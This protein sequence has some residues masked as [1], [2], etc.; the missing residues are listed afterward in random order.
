ME[1][2]PHELITLIG[3]FLRPKD[4]ARLYLCCKYWRK[5]CFDDPQIEHCKKYINVV[6]QL[7]MIEYHIYQQLKDAKNIH[8]STRRVYNN[9]LGERYSFT[10]KVNKFIAIIGKRRTLIEY[11][12]RSVDIRTFKIT[13]KN[14]YV[15][16][17]YFYVNTI[18]INTHMFK[19][20]C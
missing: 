16:W 5:E 19:C 18:S 10:R 2:L 12:K 6:N 15:D 9:T 8:V 17:Y 4:R 11:Y 20:L 13:H 1:T 14:T 3:A 7:N